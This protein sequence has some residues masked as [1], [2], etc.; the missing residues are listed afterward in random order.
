MS[1]LR[2]MI[3]R[4]LNASTSV[5]PTDDTK[6]YEVF[7]TL[8]EGRYYLNSILV[9]NPFSQVL[10]NYFYDG[11]HHIT[12]PG[13]KIVRRASTNKGLTYG[14]KT[15]VYD[16]TDG[17]MQVQ[18]PSV[19]IDNNGRTHFV[20][21]CHSS[22]SVTG[23]THEIRYFYSDNDGAT[24]STPVV[25]PFPSTSL[26]TMRFYGRIT[27]R[28]GVLITPCYFFTE[29]G[30][31]SVTERWILRST[32]NGA[33]W[34]WVLVDGPGSANLNE[35]EC[36]W[37]NDDI[38]FMITRNEDT[39]GFYMYKSL[40][41]GLTWTALGNFSPGV[42][43]T[44]AG[45]PRVHTF[46]ADDGVDYVVVY[47][48]DR[49]NDRLYAIYGRLSVG[50]TGGRSVFNINT[51]TLLR[52]D[53]EW[54]HYG[55]MFH[56]NNNMNCRGAWPREAFTVFLQDNEMIYFETPTT[57]YASV[58]DVLSPVTIYDHLTDPQGIYTWR[59]LASNTTN[60]WGSVNVSNQITLLKSLRPGPTEIN[61]SATAGGI[62]LGDG[63]QFDGTKALTCTASISHFQFLQYSSV[64]ESDVNY[65]IYFIAT[66][67][68]TSNPDAAYALFG[69]NGASSG[70]K[71]ASMWYD[72]RVSQSRNNAIVFNIAK[73]VALNFIVQCDTSNI[74]T[75][76][77]KFCGCL[78]IDLS[79]SVNNNKVKFYINGVLQSTTVSVYNTG[80]VTVPTYQL[81]LGG[82]GNSVASLMFVGKIYD[83]VV[84]NA[85][86]LPAVR[87]DMINTLMDLEGL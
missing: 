6:T 68:N 34:S 30:D 58:Y 12:D 24:I 27:Y 4:T 10:T 5:I 18:D 81:Q 49:G 40:D 69:N 65:T 1:L 37:V 23:A 50:V 61:L 52:Q 54:I 64:G 73:G 29:E 45:P 13:K 77:T 44:I 32:D 82:P 71:G 84:Q 14:A 55:D 21:D 15:T 42:L 86:D 11:V 72:D 76:N 17:S 9:Y 63:M 22:I 85:I 66:F 3:S 26:A 48:A 35:S 28:D 53:T 19:G 7:S 41:K 43:F 56:Y 20:V 33:S 38:V 8:D 2:A 57:H 46:K 67:G 39:K 51:R 78:E 74:I 59:G 25:I 83:W 62:I 87:N 70:N 60:D 75:P 36:F 31:L 79:Q 16:P 47:M 80:V